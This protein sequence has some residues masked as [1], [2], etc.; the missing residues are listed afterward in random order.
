[1]TQFRVLEKLYI[2]I[3]NCMVDL[4]YK[5]GDI[6]E[7]SENNLG[8]SFI[9]N[10]FIIPSINLYEWV[11]T[12]K[13]EEVLL[14]KSLISSETK[15]TKN[16]NKSENPYG[17]KV[18]LAEAFS[19]CRSNDLLIKDDNGFLWEYKYGDFEVM[20][21]DLERVVR[22]SEYYTLED[23]QTEMF[24]LVPKHKEKVDKWIKVESVDDLIKIFQKQYTV[25]LLDLDN[26]KEYEFKNPNSETMNFLL[27]AIIRKNMKLEYLEE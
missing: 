19:A 6:I 1:M 3:E 27:E 8:L 13:I 22:M 7:I 18:Y 17:R 23:L 25:K 5:I 15:E 24:D 9:D 11:I 26:N 14:N 2:K 4:N 10:K 12:G 20:N 21:K 16:M